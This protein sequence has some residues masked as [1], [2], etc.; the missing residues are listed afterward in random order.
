MR[1]QLMPFARMLWIV[2]VKLMAP[3][4]DER[5]VRWI[6]KI[7]ASMPPSGRKALSDSGAYEV[8]PADGGVKNTLA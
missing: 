1:P 7:H 5:P 6:M 8:Q 2:A 3:S 4:S